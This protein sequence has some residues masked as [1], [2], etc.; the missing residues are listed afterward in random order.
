VNVETFKP[1]MER[2]LKA[3]EKY[4]VCIDKT[5]NEFLESMQR[6]MKKAIDAYLNRAPN[7]RHGIALDNQITIILSQND[8]DERP[9]CGIYFNLFSP[10]AEKLH[11]KKSKS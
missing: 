1:E 6:L 4:I 7:L 5:P 2:A 8:N 9:L 10:Y 11:L 3:Y